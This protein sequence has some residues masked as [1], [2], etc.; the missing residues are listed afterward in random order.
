MDN[1][2]D[3]TVASYGLALDR[4]IAGGDRA[5]LDSLTP[6]AQADLAELAERTG[7]AGFADGLDHVPVT[8]S[9]NAPV[10]QAGT[11]WGPTGYAPS[12][13]AAR[14]ADPTQN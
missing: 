2:D 4:Y 13:D 11:G 9:H 12:Q 7:D 14:Q 1:T 8:A 5:M 6:T 3:R 10:A